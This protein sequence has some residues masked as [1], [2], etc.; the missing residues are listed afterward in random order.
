MCFIPPSKLR[1][2]KCKLLHKSRST[3]DQ[4]SELLQK[5]DD[6]PIL[7][8]ASLVIKFVNKFRHGVRLSIRIGL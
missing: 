6:N 5:G 8:P 7:A 3:S 4:V 1:Q 2:K